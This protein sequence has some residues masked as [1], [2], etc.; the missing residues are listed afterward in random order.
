MTNY[1]QKFKRLYIDDIRN[2]KSP[3]WDIVRSSVEAIQYLENN[4]CPEY[5]SFD[6]DL[7]GDDTAM[8]IVKYMVNQ[9]LDN[10]GF[11]PEGFEFNTHS[12]NPVGSAN[13]TGYLNSYLKQR[14]KMS[15]KEYENSEMGEKSL[16]N[17]IDA[18]SENRGVYID[19]LMWEDYKDYL[20]LV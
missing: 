8:V 17:A 3:N 1:D 11:I 5:I 2:P 13:I 16:E 4:G 7:N 9:D 10:P 12:A 15:F 20:T 18:V 6:H 19:D 14:S